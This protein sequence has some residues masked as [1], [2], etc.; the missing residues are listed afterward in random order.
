MSG[1]RFLTGLREMELSEHVLLTTN[2]LKES[3]DIFG[4]DLRKENMEESLL[5]IDDDELNALSSD[6]E[7]CMLNE[8]GAEVAAVIA[9]YI[10]KVIFDKNK[11]EV[12]KNLL[13]TVNSD[14][15]KFNYLN[16]LSRGGLVIPSIDLLH[17]VF[18]IL[19]CISD[20]AKKSSSPER[21]RVEYVL[22]ERN[23]YPS[24]F[25]CRN[26]KHLLS[27]VSRVITN[28]YF[29]NEQKKLRDTVRKDNIKDFKQRQT[30][31]ARLS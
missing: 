28:T 3:V 30:K 19:D 8:E 13:I 4:E 14:S 16:K 5:I 21:K 2:L 9:G 25:L 7:S 22:S 29:N 15:I 23:D 24:S 18:A 11:C 12:C 17:Y 20:I 1:D 10:F 27:K 31:R 26:H 6:L